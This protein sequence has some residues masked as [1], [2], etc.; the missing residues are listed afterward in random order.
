MAF[1]RTAWTAVGGFPED[2]YAGEDVAFSRAMTRHVDHV[3]FSPNAAVGWR[4]HRGWRETAR[5]YRRY[6]RGGIRTRP[7]YPHIVR[8]AGLIGAAGATIALFAAGM[9]AYA[10]VALGL[11]ALYVALPFRRAR[12]SE[13]TLGE[14]GWRIPAIIA[15]K[16]TSNIVGA[17]GG[18]I[19]GL[20]HRRQPSPRH[21]RRGPTSDPRSADPQ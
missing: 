10:G 7:R 11:G 15:M 16:D 2:L 12:R 9:W 8:V 5:T 20:L 17:V 21:G 19:D 1:S 4:P 6:A 3:A 18:A 13:L 14:Y